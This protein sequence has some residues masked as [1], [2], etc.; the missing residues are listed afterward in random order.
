VETVYTAAPQNR[1]P[2]TVQGMQILIGHMK[3]DLQNH[4]M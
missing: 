1:F 2:L 4:G 3:G